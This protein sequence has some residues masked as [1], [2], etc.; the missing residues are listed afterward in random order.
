MRPG[1][2]PCAEEP[3]RQTGQLTYTLKN[4]RKAVRSELEGARKVRGGGAE[5]SE[6]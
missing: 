6:R 3:A 5:W 4:K 2:E 1:G